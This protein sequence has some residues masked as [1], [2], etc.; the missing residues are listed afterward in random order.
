M[1]GEVDGREGWSWLEHEQRPGVS[2]IGSLMIHEPAPVDENC[3][4]YQV[5]IE[6]DEHN[7]A[8]DLVRDEAGRPLTWILTPDGTADVRDHEGRA[9]LRPAPPEVAR[10]AEEWLADE[11][12]DAARG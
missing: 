9:A 4:P 10:A 6:Y 11:R 3:W 8:L 2:T 5:L 1:T 7:Q 12:G